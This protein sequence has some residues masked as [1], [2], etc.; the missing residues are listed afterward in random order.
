MDIKRKLK[1]ERAKYGVTQAQ[2]MERMG[3]NGRT[4]L[5]QIEAGIVEATDEYIEQLFNCIKT[6][7][8]NP[9][10]EKPS[11]RTVQSKV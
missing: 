7:K 4:Y 11:K 10:H 9:P 1:V 5:A 3:K 2:V 6:F 8:D